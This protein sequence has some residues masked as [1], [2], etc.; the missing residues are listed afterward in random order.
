MKVFFKNIFRTIFFRLFDS[1]GIDKVLILNGEIRREQILEKD[2]LDDLSSA[3]YRVFSQ[4]GEDGIISWLIDIIEPKS[5]S[6]IEFGVEDFRESNCR[7]LIQHRNWSGLV[8]DGCKKNIESIKSQDLSWRHDLKAQHAFINRDNINDLILQN[9]FED[10]IGLLSTDIDGV[11]YFVL[12]E[13]KNKAD[14][15][16]VEYNDLFS[17]RTVSVPYDSNF[18]R[19]KA[20]HSGMYWGASLDAFKFLLEKKEYTFVGTNSV[21]TN[22]FFIK[23]NKA[24]LVTSRLKNIKQWPCNIRDVRDVN[25]NLKLQNY[26]ES[27]NL[28]ADLPLVDVVN[29]DEIKVKELFN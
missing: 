5:K 24:K 20:H 23:T 8:I 18:I 15:I 9:G 1:V 28:I 14:I 21:G 3:E 25:G 7:Y 6:F 12:K 16:V 2:F 27:W 4:W 19:N 22:A 26:R 29:G 17:G 11:D 10:D 13:I